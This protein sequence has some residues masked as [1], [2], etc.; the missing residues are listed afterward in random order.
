LIKNPHV[1]LPIIHCHCFSKSEKPEIELI[2]VS[3]FAVNNSINL[4]LY[5]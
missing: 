1:D 4:K 2:E 3:S 5:K